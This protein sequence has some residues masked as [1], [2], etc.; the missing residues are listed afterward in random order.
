LLLCFA[1][2]FVV[3]ALPQ[4]LLLLWIWLVQQI[5]MPVRYSPRRIL[6]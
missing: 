5:H 6:K 1:L 4:A 2:P 3:F